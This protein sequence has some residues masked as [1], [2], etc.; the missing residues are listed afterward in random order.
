MESRVKFYS[1]QNI[2][3]ASQTSCMKTFYVFF[4]WLFFILNQVSGYVSCFTVKLH[5]C[6]VD[7]E[8]LS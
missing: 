1:T 7:R 2:S 5:D 3:G 6:S 4:I 8:S